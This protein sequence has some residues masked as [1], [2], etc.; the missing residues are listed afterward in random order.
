MWRDDDILDAAAQE[1]Q[2]H[3][4]A[5]REEQAVHGLDALHEVQ[6]HPLLERAIARAGLGVLREFPY[7]STWKKRPWRAGGGEDLP[8]PAPFPAPL[9]LPRDR[10]R[11]DLVILERPGLLIA[12]PVKVEKNARREA[13]EVKGTLFEALTQG[14]A[15]LPSPSAPSAVSNTVSSE[16]ALWLEV[17]VVGQYE[18]ADGVPGP[19]PSYASRLVRS[20]TTDLGKLAADASIRHAG[21]LLVL[22][23]ATPE[24]A[25]HDL[26]TLA[27]RC[28]DRGLPIS[29]PVHRRVPIQ[30]RIGNAF[31]TLALFTMRT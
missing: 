21:A 26:L 16:D 7:P 22:F 23:T 29:S 27:H 15:A 14:D 2:A 11:C 24:I 12:D 30:D 5:L 31:C 17:K 8:L 10:D 19:N 28:L 13:A 25:D 4:A 9:P 1:L 20:V 18:H 3:D 6:L